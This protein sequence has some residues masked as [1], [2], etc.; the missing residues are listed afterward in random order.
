MALPPRL[1]KT[2]GSGVEVSGPGEITVRLTNTDTASL[3]G[4]YYAE[5]QLTDSS[6]N[7]SKVRDADDE[8]FELR[9]LGDLD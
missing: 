4:K 9:F 2:L 7:I 3:S 5:I 8:P 1:S 6:G